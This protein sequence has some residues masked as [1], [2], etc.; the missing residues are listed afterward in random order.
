MATNNLKLFPALLLLGLL[1]ACSQEIGVED[2]ETP[3]LPEIIPDEPTQIDIQETALP[4]IEDFS[5]ADAEE[6]F[7]PGYQAL[8]TPAS[9]QIEEDGN[10]VTLT[11]PWPS[12][13][14]PTCCFFQTDDDGELIRNAPFSESLIS[15]FRIVDNK[16]QMS[17]SRFS[18]AQI[19][20]DLTPNIPER[21]A[22]TTDGTQGASLALGS[23]GEL[24]LTN[25]YRVSFCLVDYGVQGTGASNLELWV[26]NNSGGRSDESIH[27]VSSLLLR[28]ALV[29]SPVL[30]AGRRIVVDVPGDAYMIDNAGDRVGPTLGVIQPIALPNI[31]AGTF[32]SFLQMRISAGGYVVIRDL[33]VGR[34]RTMPPA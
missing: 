22:D 28:A 19:L 8:A 13:Y 2:P 12:L 24:N 18:I 9:N 25:P 30:V 1:A 5:A 7:S 11:D 14:Y 15:R 32:S 20:S 31:P 10:Q 27:G 21:K 34:P 16:L 6:F 17:N 3:E 33:V 4:I 23:W 29:T 26:D